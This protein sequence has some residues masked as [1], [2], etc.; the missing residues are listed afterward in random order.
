M[1]KNLQVENFSWDGKFVRTVGGRTRQSTKGKTYSKLRSLEPK[2]VFSATL[3]DEKNETCS[4]KSTPRRPVEIEVG[5]F[6]VLW[7]GTE[8]PWH[9]YYLRIWACMP[10]A[11]SS[12][13][14]RAKIVEL[15]YWHL[16]LLETT[17]SIFVATARFCNNQ[18]L[19][20]LDGHDYFSK[21]ATASQ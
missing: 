3:G 12:F 4:A 2:G 7:I 16:A 14:R 6:Y 8:P 21:H 1:N 20:L 5:N 13:R 19:S 15:N 17:S 9:T 18:E 11:L 10:P